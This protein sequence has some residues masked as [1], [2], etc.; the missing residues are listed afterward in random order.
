V[1]LPGT[2]NAGLSDGMRIHRKRSYI[3]ALS[4]SSPVPKERIIFLSAF[5]FCINTARRFDK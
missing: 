2:V 4:F 5:F 3:S 1:F